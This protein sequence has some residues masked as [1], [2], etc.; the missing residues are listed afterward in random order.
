MDFALSTNWNA[1]RHT[2][3]AV[4]VD[5]IAALGFDSLELGYATTPEQ[6]PGIKSRLGRMPVRSVHAFCPVPVSAPH[7]YPE[8]HLL[9]SFDEDERALA[10]M[11]VRKTIEFAGSMAAAVVVLHAGRVFLD[12]PFDFV[13]GRRDSDALR[14]VLKEGKDDVKD[15]AYTKL[16]A[17]AW[18][19]R[20]ARGAKM[21]PL[22][23]AELEK[24][25]PVLEKNHLKLAFENLPSIEGFPDEDEMDALAKA[26]KGA[27]F[28]AWYD[29]GHARIRANLGWTGPE[30]EVAAR[31]AP[32]LVGCHLNDVGGLDDDHKPIG[33]GTV[34]FAALKGVLASPSVI[35]VVEPGPAVAPED[36]RRGLE[37]IRHLWA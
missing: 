5:E 10:A 13:L 7:G 32:Y 20:R 19:R 14:A 33:G 22:F 9:A 4:L 35:S 34:N 27:P 23:R 24:L 36:V 37:A 28:G 16:L 8:L 25:A 31:A 30:T 21:L 11:M 29:T 2:D 3:G 6:V 15:S 12:S 18:E 26:L 1:R 17:K